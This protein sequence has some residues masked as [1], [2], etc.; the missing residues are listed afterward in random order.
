MI[1]NNN[2]HQQKKTPKPKKQTNKKQKE[3]KTQKTK[4]KDTLQTLT[5]AERYWQ[6][7]HPAFQKHL[8]LKSGFRVRLP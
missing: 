3:K 5:F 6:E 1:T 7:L 2:N 8:Y 4:E